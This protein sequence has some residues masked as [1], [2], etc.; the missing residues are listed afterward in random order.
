MEVLGNEKREGLGR[1][2]ESRAWLFVFALIS[3]I[4]LL[5]S[6]YSADASVFR[7]ARE[8]AMEAA[9][10]FLSIFAGPAAYLEDRIGEVRHYFFV[11][12]QNK[13][14]REQIEDLRYWEREAR[15]LRQ[16][17]A[18]YEALE[19]YKTFSDAAPINAF[20]FGESNNT[21]K[22]TMLVN[23]G[24][25]DAVKS[26]F[27]VVDD[28][29]FVGRV[30]DVSR[31]ASRI[32]LLTDAQSRVPIMVEGSEVEGMLQ[33]KTNRQPAITFTRFDDLSQVQVGQRVITSGTEG[34][35]PPGLPVGVIATVDEDEAMVQLFANYTRTRLVRIIPFSPPILDEALA[36][37]GEESGPLVAENSDAAGRP[38]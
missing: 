4:L 9:S 6:L 18:S 16:L 15:D 33:G 8:T 7:K 24:G 11:L 37:E 27:A 30:I 12:E 19:A 21:F 32:L 28:R 3:V 34:A 26:G 38:Q 36:D 29:G 31:N 22:H 10:P 1:K 23:A 5:S 14:L 13:A 35:M 2:S 20:V 17:T 25:V